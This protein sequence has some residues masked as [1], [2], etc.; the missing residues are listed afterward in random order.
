MAKVGV[1]K[2]DIEDESEAESIL[3]K[4]RRELP[5]SNPSIDLEDCDKVLRVEFSG[6]LIDEP[7]L[8]EI[9]K[10]HGY[11]MEVLP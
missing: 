3:K 9:L 5:G 6:Y 4:I 11:K 7:G 10:D 8:K 1:Y 2:T